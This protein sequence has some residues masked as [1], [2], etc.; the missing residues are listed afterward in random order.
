[1]FWNFRKF[2]SKL[3]QPC[4]KYYSDLG[5]TFGVHC[6][7]ERIA[8]G[9]S[10][11]FI[12]FCGLCFYWQSLLSNQWPQCRTLPS[13][14]TD[15]I[16]FEIHSWPVNTYPVR[17]DILR[18]SLDILLLEFDVL[19]DLWDVTVNS[20]FSGIRFIKVVKCRKI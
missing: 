4:K 8:K 5:G 7:A 9:G 15:E 10:K 2:L 3:L 17:P 16:F 20:Y 1:M 13:G 6:N 12:D 19:N 11:M 14:R 18:F